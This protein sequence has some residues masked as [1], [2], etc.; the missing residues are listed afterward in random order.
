MTWQLIGHSWAIQL[1][2]SHVEHERLRHAYLFTGP[3]GVGR[4]SL[5]LKFAQAINCS[6]PTEPGM[7]CGECRNCRQLKHMQ[8]PDLAVVAAEQPG[9]MLKVDQV[10]ELQRQL[11]LTTIQARYRIALFLRFEEANPNA[12]NALLKTL[13]EPPDHVILLLTAENPD[14]LLPTVTSRCEIIRLRPVP[15]LDLQTALQKRLPVSLAEAELLAA[16]SGGRPGEAI[17]L[18]WDADG[19][20]LRLDWLKE[21]RAMMAAS[22]V[23]RFAYAQ[24]IS[25]D[26]A[27]MHQAIGVWISFWRDVLLRASAAQAPAMSNPDLEAEIG[28]AADS[29]TREQIVGVIRSLQQAN[30]LL[31]RYANPRLVAEVLMLQLP[32]ASS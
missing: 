8:H 29:A 24:A 20:A 5:A 13:E 18:H 30:D 31:A 26:R 25:K 15:A 17:R 19:M 32:G 22:R 7:P 12:A 11:A 9:G 21:Q 14:V 27:R 3:A 6:E 28:A 23:E 2:R 10:R 16:V 4:R 1:L